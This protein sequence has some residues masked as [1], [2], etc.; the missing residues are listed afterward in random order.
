MKHRIAMWRSPP[1]ESANI[2]R[3]GRAGVEEDANGSDG[4]S[5]AD[6][7]ADSAPRRN[8][9]VACPPLAWTHRRPRVRTPVEAAEPSW[10]RV[11]RT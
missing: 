5:L 9:F 8:R 2:A 7:I 11:S 4:S 3:R 1:E 10:L 6:A